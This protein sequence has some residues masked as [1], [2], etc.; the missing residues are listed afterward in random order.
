MVNPP[1][2]RPRIAFF[3][4]VRVRGVTTKRDQ[5]DSSCNTVTSPMYRSTC[6]QVCF[7]V[8]LSISL[9]AT[10]ALA[11]KATSSGSSA[12][13]SREAVRDHFSYFVSC[14]FFRHFD[15]CQHA[16]LMLCA[17][18]S[19]FFCPRITMPRLPAISH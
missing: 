6:L 19:F 15:G 11:E 3:V 16:W 14:T 1:K 18:F 8:I 17:I 4:L 10:E 7:L 9:I 12:T 5:R 2:I 13:Q